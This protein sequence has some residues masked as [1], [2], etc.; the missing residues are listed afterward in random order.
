MPAKPPV[1]TAKL[2]ELLA[3]AVHEL[4]SGQNGAAPETAD[5]AQALA[6]G[7]EKDA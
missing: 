4:A 5:E 2:A 6:D 3:R 7:E 1:D